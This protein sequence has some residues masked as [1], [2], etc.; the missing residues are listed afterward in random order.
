M[1]LN[2]VLTDEQNKAISYRADAEGIPRAELIRQAISSYLEPA[3]CRPGADEVA[4]LEEKIRTLEAV[5]QERDQ[6]IEVLARLTAENDRMTMDLTTATVDRDRIHE[7]S[8]AL[9]G[10]VDRLKIGAPGMAQAL[11]EKKDEVAWLRGQ[12]ALLNDKLTPP[13][14]PDRAGRRWWQIW[15]G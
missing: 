13:A 8:G 14:L 5:T 15:R 6:A 1:R 9:K 2:V 12:V 10:E 7:Q 4:A 3:P 11:D